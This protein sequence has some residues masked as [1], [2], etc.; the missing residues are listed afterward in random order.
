MADGSIQWEEIATK[1]YI[2]QTTVHAPD[3]NRHKSSDKHHYG[4]SVG[5]EYSTTANGPTKKKKIKEK[6][7]MFLR[8]TILCQYSIPELM[9]YS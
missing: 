2:G 8:L 7:K 1:I 3:I 5:P 6:N 4:C 9:R